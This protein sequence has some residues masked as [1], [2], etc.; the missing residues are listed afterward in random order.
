MAGRCGTGFCDA[1]GGTGKSKAGDG[2]PGLGWTRIMVSVGSQGVG[3][4]LPHD[5]AGRAWRGEI[6]RVL[7]CTGV[8]GRVVGRDAEISAAV[9]AEMTGD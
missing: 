3:A 7:D 6:G 2:R 9:K 5:V 4:L 1:G 8:R